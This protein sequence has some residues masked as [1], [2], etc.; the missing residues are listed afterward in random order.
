MEVRSGLRYS[1]NERRNFPFVYSRLYVSTIRNKHLLFGVFWVQRAREREEKVHFTLAERKFNK[2][3]T[4]YFESQRLKIA[5]L[6]TPLSVFNNCNNLQCSSILNISIQTCFGSRT[7]Y[8]LRS[9]MGET[10]LLPYAGIGVLAYRYRDRSTLTLR[11]APH[12]Q[13]YRARLQ[14]RISYSLTQSLR[15]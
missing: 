3:T 15:I 1:P 5:L 10:R 13:P 4:S 9:K 7:L 14:D 8:V 12:L 2:I 11:L 6:E